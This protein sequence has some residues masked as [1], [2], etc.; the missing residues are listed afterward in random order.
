MIFLMPVYFIFAVV[1]IYKLMKKYQGQHKWR[2]FLLLAF[3]FYLPVGWDVI[4]GRAYFYYLCNKNGGVHI[5]DTV[6]LSPEYWDKDG[7]P[8]FYTED[9]G[10]FD[11]SVFG[12]RYIFNVLDSKGPFRTKKE[13]NQIIDTKT[14]DILGEWVKYSTSGGWVTNTGTPF[15]V[16]G[17]RCHSY[18]ET[19]DN[20]LSKG[21][22]NS[23]H[24]KFTSYIFLNK[25][26]NKDDE[27]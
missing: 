24:R 1:V 27:L 22:G 20:P 14:G 19:L 23:T 4:L 12:G 17:I 5:Y 25:L 15:G 8:R 6:E 11:S 3:L 2:R 7:R 10:A 18:D 13:L 16:T 9:R 21:M 26:T